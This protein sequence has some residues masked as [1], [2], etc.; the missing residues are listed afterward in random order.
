VEKLSKYNINCRIWLIG[1]NGTFLGMGRVKLMQEIEKT[2][3]ISKA[4]KKLGM[5]YRKAWES[6]DAINKEA[7]KPLVIKTSG[8]KGGG[9]A[10]LTEDGKKTIKNYLKIVKNTEAFISK[11]LKKI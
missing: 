5:S 2:G 10:V 6:I 9:G 3:S 1:E 4:A 8:G 11:Q 7:E